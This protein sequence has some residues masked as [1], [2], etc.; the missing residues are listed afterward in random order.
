[1]AMRG[2]FKES[3][4]VE[5]IPGSTGDSTGKLAA[6]HPF[7]DV[8]WGDGTTVSKFDDWWSDYNQTLATAT[9]RDLDLRSLA[10]GPRGTVTFAEIR[11]ILFKTDTDMTLTVHPTTN[12]WVSLGAAFSILVG[13]GTSFRYLCPTDGKLPVGNTNKVL[14]LKNETLGTATYSIVILGTTA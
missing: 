1:M 8:L 3:F 2:S 7:L 9:D 4:A 6:Q 14:R 11:G 10:S 13:A 5:Y 12:P